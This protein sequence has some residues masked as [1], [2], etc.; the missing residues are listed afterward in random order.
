MRWRKGNG[1]KWAVVSWFCKQNGPPPTRKGENKIP[2]KVAEEEIPLHFLQDSRRKRVEVKSSKVQDVC[3]QRT[4]AVVDLL[5]LLRARGVG[6]GA[7]TPALNGR[8]AQAA[9]SAGPP[10]DPVAGPVPRPDP[11]GPAARPRRHHLPRRRRQRPRQLHRRLAAGGAAR[12]GNY[13]VEERGRIRRRHQVFHSIAVSFFAFFFVVK[14]WTFTFPPLRDGAFEGQ[15]EYRW[16][17]GDIYKGEVF[18]F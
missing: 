14:V 9:G 15:G 5:P 18:I 11:G 7:D 1:V 10:P 12:E 3:T 8:P 6:A 2:F 16:P 13:E 4:P 17:N